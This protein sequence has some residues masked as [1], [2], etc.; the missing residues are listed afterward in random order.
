MKYAAFIIG[1]FVIGLVAMLAVMQ[2]IP[3]GFAVQ[4]EPVPLI[5]KV[6]KP[7]FC[8]SGENVQQQIAE[9]Q[10]AYYS[11]VSSAEEGVKRREISEKTAIKVLNNY[12]EGSCEKCQE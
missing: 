8:A 6:N 5:E 10:V 4:E 9:Q 12:A 1:I 11:I 3:T 2:P 7:C